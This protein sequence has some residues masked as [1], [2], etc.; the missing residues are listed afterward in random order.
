MWNDVFLPG[1]PLPEIF[2]R[3]TVVYLAIFFMLRFTPRR[4]VGSFSTTNLIVIVIIADA[5][6]NAMA[7]EYRSISDGLLLVATIV[8]WSIVLD[9]A[10]F[11][12]PAV[13][14][15]VKPP[16]RVLVR[17]GRLDRRNL[18]RELI[19]EDELMA[20]LREQGTEELSELDVVLEPDGRV[21]VHKRDDDDQA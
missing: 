17:N 19:T 21:S 18:R 16:P 4:E 14:R 13:A 8:G 15:I 9:A 6:Q 10:A 12:W 11:R 2:I 20:H 7:G 1:T 5:A 3:G